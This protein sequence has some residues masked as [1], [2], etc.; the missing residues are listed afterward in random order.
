MSTHPHAHSVLFVGSA[1]PRSAT[2]VFEAI[3]EHVSGLCTT[4]P[5]GDQAGW[6][7]PVMAH[8]AASPQLEAADQVLFHE[9]GTMRVP[10]F[11]LKSGVKPAELRLGPYGYAAQAEKSYGE[12]IRL[13][14][15]GKFPADTRFQVTLPSPMVSIMFLLHPPEQVL[16]AAEA[17]FKDEIDALLRAVPPKDLLISWDVCEPVSEEVQRRPGEASP[18]FKTLMPYLPSMTLSLDSV[19][20]A[21]A[22]VPAACGLGMHLCYGS[23]EN[24]HSIEPIDAQLLVDFMNGISARVTRS[25]D[26]MHFPVPIERDDAAYF[27]PLKGLKIHPETELYLGLVHMEDGTA[28]AARRIQAAKAVLGKFGVASECGLSSTTLEDYLATLDMHRKVAQLL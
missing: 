1:P 27:A 13:R 15:E 4:V 3:S 9:G 24:K 17:A 2:A 18:L 28:G 26:W 23:A 21:A 16:P 12:F 7:L 25:I 19:A 11:R 10:V 20:R 8:Y 5:D 22:M 14:K 6:L